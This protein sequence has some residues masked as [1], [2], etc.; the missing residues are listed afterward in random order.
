MPSIPGFDAVKEARKWKH[1]VWLEMRDMTF[2]EKKAYLAKGIEEMYG[3]KP[4]ERPARR[5]A[6][7]K[8]ALAFA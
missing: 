2:E 4:A 5:V 8:P 3:K 6:A 1:A 7:R